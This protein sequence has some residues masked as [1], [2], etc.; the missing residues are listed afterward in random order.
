MQDFLF[1]AEIYPLKI[2][3]AETMYKMMWGYLFPEE[4]QDSQRRQVS[5][6]SEAPKHECSF[7]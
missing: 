1:Q 3:L 4:K 2:H 7:A 5:L 6:N